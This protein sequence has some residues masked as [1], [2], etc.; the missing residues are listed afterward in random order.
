MTK[1]HAASVYIYTA[2]TQAHNT[3]PHVLTCTHKMLAYAHVRT[4]AGNL[5]TA[6]IFTHVRAHTHACA[7]TNV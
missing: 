4:H 5:H 7:H 3:V 6:H 1:S 2:H